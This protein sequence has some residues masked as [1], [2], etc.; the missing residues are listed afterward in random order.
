MRIRDGS[1][2]TITSAG[3][4]EHLRNVSVF[5]PSELSL[6]PAAN[7]LE[8]LA[9]N[10]RLLLA[11]MRAFTLSVNRFEAIQAF[12]ETEQPASPTLEELNRYQTAQANAAAHNAA[13][14]AQL[15]ADLLALRPRVNLVWEQLRRQSLSQGFD[16]ASKPPDEIGKKFGELWK[17]NIQTYQ[18]KFRF[19]DTE[20]TQLEQ[21]SYQLEERL[22]GANAPVV[23]PDMLLSDEWAEMMQAKLNELRGLFKL[24]VPPEV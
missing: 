12:R 21:A 6:E 22:R 2:K 15:I 20:M 18:E 24:D 10:S 14:C 4:P 23:L 3:L 19:S 5:E 17:S 7:D 9:Q 8:A 13:T 11:A 1:G 16:P